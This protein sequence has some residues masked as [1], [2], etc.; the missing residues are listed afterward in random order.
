MQRKIENATFCIQKNITDAPA[1]HAS[2][3]AKNSA[4]WLA[5]G[6]S[7]LHSAHS[8]KWSPCNLIQTQTNVKLY[9]IDASSVV[10]FTTKLSL[11]FPV[12]AVS[13]KLLHLRK[14]WRFIRRQNGHLWPFKVGNT[15]VDTRH[16]GMGVNF[17]CEMAMRLMRV[18]YITNVSECLCLYDSRAS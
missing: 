10:V 8:R 5:G 14:P 15:A 7:R 1:P 9:N 4:F 6:H 17:V 2:S 16:A 11:V 13:E 3:S 12:I 18:K